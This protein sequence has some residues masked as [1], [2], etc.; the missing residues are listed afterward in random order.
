MELNIAV[1]MVASIVAPM[2]PDIVGE[3]D[4][5][6]EETTRTEIATPRRAIVGDPEKGITST[7][8]T[9]PT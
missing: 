8:S 3:A 6:R 5:R 4:R 9:P 2:V 7:A 1:A